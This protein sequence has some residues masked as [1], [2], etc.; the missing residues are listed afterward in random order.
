MDFIRSSG[1]SSNGFYVGELQAGMGIRGTVVGDPV[2]SEDQRL[3][4]LGMLSRGARGINVYAHYPMSS[5][6]EAGGY[7]LI[8]LDGSVTPR[9]KKMGKLAHM[10]A[11]NQSLFREAQPVK[12]D[13]AL[14]YNPLSH[15]VGGE[16]H[17]SRSGAVRESLQGLYLPF[18]QSN[19]PMDFV[20]LRE[21]EAGSLDGYKVAYL[22]YPLMLTERAARGLT[23]YVEKGGVLLAEARCGWND[24]RGFSQDVIPGFGLHEVFGVRE[25]RLKMNE[26]VKIRIVEQD[27]LLGELAPGSRLEGVGIQE[28][29]VPG[30]KARVL[31][32]F[33]DGSAAI[34]VSAFGKGRAILV[35]SFLGMANAQ[36]R[37]PLT[38]KLLLGI[39]NSAGVKP[40]PE[41]GNVPDGVFLEVRLLNT[42]KESVLY[43]FNHSEKSVEPKL[44]YTRGKD[45]ETDAQLDLSNLE[46]QAGEIRVLVVVE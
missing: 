2:T 39:A 35:G 15:L 8:N 24:D 45:L 37:N 17:L 21:V 1:R 31:A 22:P 23:E 32:S 34:T 27:P 10:V 13:V 25:G 44:P 9:A 7:G 42:G 36:E 40:V 38:E 16:Q 14:I 26:K 28:E 4:V 12:A 19:I 3:W 11:R 33:S 5:G 18:W 20:H 41:I 30:D 43:L 46:L 6:Y 29:L